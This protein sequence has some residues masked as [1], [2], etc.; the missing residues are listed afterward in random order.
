MTFYLKLA[1][2]NLDGL[3]DKKLIYDSE[4]IEISE[5]GIQKSSVLF[6]ML[7]CCDPDENNEIPILFNC[8]RDTLKKFAE[9]CEY[10]SELDL[11]IH[12]E[13][14]YVPIQGRDLE[15]C[16]SI[17]DDLD[18]IRELHKLSDYLGQ[19]ELQE[20]LNKRI[21]HH[22]IRGHCAEDVLKICETLGIKLD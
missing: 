7:E 10:A 19:P 9:Y 4:G 5:K 1:K 22:F 13:H 3:G 18:M 2:R 14:K 12:I 8:S 20:L 6:N 16:E 21:A 17:G 15:F 11:V